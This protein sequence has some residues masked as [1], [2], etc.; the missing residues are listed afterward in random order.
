MEKFQ[1]FSSPVLP[2]PMKDVDTDMILPAQFLTSVSKTGWGEFLFQRLRTRD[3]NFPLN[4]PAY[5]GAKILLSDSNFG[6]GSSREHAVWAL[7]QYGF[8]V[9][10]AKS[11]ADIFSANSG[12]NGLLLVSL[13][14]EE[15]DALFAL[16][17]KDELTLVVDLEEQ[18]VVLPDKRKINFAYDSFRR[19]CLLNGLD[20]IDYILSNRSEI[21]AFRS[22][23]AEHRF[24]STLDAIA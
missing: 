21:D 10:L 17:E 18:V 23:Q 19:H 3:P 4:N 22:R 12:K 8:R 20:D 2:L 6:C 5:A 9:V 14:S 15:I 1:T 11:F 16:A 24:F 7:R 13:P